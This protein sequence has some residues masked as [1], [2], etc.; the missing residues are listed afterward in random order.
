MLFAG[1]ST[2]VL[3]KLIA[4]GLG[5]KLGDITVGRFSDGEVAVE[6][7]ENVRGSDV[8]VIQSTCPPTNEHLM[9]L[10]IMVDALRRASAAR[11][12]AVIPYFGYARQDRRPRSARV[13]ITARLVAD[14][15]AMVGVHRVLTVDLHAEQIQ[16]FFNIPLDNVYG[17]PL[18]LDYLSKQPKENLVVV[19][20]DMGGVARCQALAKRLNCELAMVDK[21]RP[22][23]N[24]AR[25][26]NVVGEIKDKHCVLVDDIVDTAGT[27]C[28]AATELMERGALSVSAYCIHPVLS[29]NAIE[30]IEKSPLSHLVVTDSIPLKE[31]AL[32]CQ[33]IELISLAP[34]LTETIRR[35][36]SAV[37]VRAL[38]TD[39]Y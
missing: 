25:V 37:S 33:K 10:V 22:R 34:M 9:E 16:G 28:N 15:L 12:T 36:Y 1:N 17:N 8:F 3:A 39:S 7:H 4:E 31:R 24:I 18:I 32:S 26:M 14:M 5:I 20:P 13:P 6:I 11:I 35:V 27:L 29:G 2:P 19:A 38:F 23:A 30:N 21:R